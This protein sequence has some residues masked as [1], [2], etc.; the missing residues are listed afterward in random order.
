MYLSNKKE[1]IK[2]A[3][4]PHAGYAFSGKLAGDVLARLADKKDFIILG[5]N[6][7]SLGSKISISQQDF[8][9]P[10]G[11]VKTNLALSNKLLKELKKQGF[12]ADTSE[13]A[14]NKEHSIEVQLPFL[15]KSQKKFEILPVL[16]KDL[17]YEECKKLAAILA[18]FIDDNLG[19]I[20]SSDLT[21]YGSAYG[22]LPFK[23]D[24]KKHIY[25]I[26]NEI[27]I[28]ILNKNSKKV[29]EL[30]SKSTVC[31]L[32][33]ITIISELAK[34]KNLKAKLVEYYTSGDITGDF[35]NCVGYAGI[36]FS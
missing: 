32:Y 34:I 18:D 27:I 29:Y 33:G 25:D 20:I 36:I 1:N 21:H 26:D 4:S 5:V 31:G 9:T 7:S 10:L 23:T 13:Q 28:N 35:S 19:L 8:E 14:H 12:E 22:F 16:L 3:I 15:Q 6:H 24:I 2:L 11:V 30:S 17:S